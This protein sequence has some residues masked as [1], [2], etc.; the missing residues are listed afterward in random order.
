MM[1]PPLHRDAVGIDRDSMRQT[2]LRTDTLDLSFC[3]QLNSIFLAATEFG[4]AARDFPVVFVK[5]GKNEKGQEEVAPLAV[6]G[7][8]Q[9]ENLFVEGHGDT[10]SWRGRYMPAV[11]R[12]YPF[13]TA[14]MAENQFAICIDRSW[15]YVG[16]QEG[17]A[18]FDADGQPSEFFKGV[19]QQLEVLEGEIARTRAIGQR[20]VELDLLRDMRFD[21]TLADGRKHTID[22]FLTVDQQRFGELK[23]ATVLELHKNG[24]LGMIHSH[25]VSLG[26]MRK[27]VDW[28]FER[29]SAAPAASP[30]LTPMA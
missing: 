12:T 2:R 15:K 14:P 7:V 6:L 20:L 16:T 10:Q 27:L 11:L 19:Q 21:A 29:T 24:M 9:N 17:Q 23:D 25:W 1:H 4:D 28:H 30:Q 5:A 26:H 13:C 18:L 22:G 3:S 8:T